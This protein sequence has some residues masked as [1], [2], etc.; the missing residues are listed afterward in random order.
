MSLSR[1]GKYD[2]AAPC[3]PCQRAHAFEV[4]TR[5][6]TAPTEPPCAYDHPDLVDGPKAR[7]AHLENELVELRELLAAAN[8]KLA[9]CTCGAAAGVSTNVL[10]PDGLS[11]S[12][13]NSQHASAAT[14]PRLA[15]EQIPATTG[16]MSE[17]VPE[18]PF[19]NPAFSS[20]SFGAFLLSNTL[21]NPGTLPIPMIS[22]FGSSSFSTGGTGSATSDV[23]PSAWPPGL[24]PPAVL[25]HLVETF[26]A[27][28]PLASRLIHKPTFMVAL[29]QL[30][31]SLDF[32]H[33]ALLH[34]IC[35]LA[36]LYSPIIAD[37][38]LAAARANA[39]A[40]LF[41][42]SISGPLDPTNGEQDTRRFP[43][44]LYDLRNIWDEGFGVS[45]I[46]LAS[47][48]L[49][50]S[51]REGDRLL[52]ML[53][54][55]IICTWYMY[56]MG[57]TI[58]VYVWVSN[59]T[60]LAGPLG[61]YASEGF[62]P[63]SRLPSN[64]LFLF[65]KPKTPSE[66]ETI[67]NIFWISYVMER[68]YNAG[69]AW[70]LTI[71]DEDISQM[72]PCRFSDFITGEHVPT[73]NRQR[74][75]TE[76]MLFTHPTLTTDSWTL[77][78]KASILISRVRS[79]NSRYRISAVSKSTG[80][81]ME[82][83]GSPTESEEFRHLDQTIA[84]FTRNIPRAFRDPVGTT[85]DPLLYTAHLLPHMA[86]IQLHDPHAKPDSPNDHSAMQMLAATRAILDLIYKL[87]GTTYDLLHLD[88]SC[89]FAWFLAGVAI[90][91]FLKAK[92]D[93]KNED[94]ILG[95]EQE[96]GVVK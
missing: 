71:N 11:L 48:S 77:Y 9:G 89:S 3:G 34:A 12:T 86:M 56:S 16:L 76:N 6:S 25:Y 66:A 72:L 44:S 13:G 55:A 54:A 63:L 57:F 17:I 18:A 31:T 37:P 60:K 23:L 53:Q 65:G 39:A 28:V 7:I 58:G 87:S 22:T 14:A 26:F 68:V 95:L 4:R 38:T 35:G 94:E 5:P 74:I 10:E 85:V 24:P 42:P 81:S 82:C 52:Q 1:N 69:T 78:I 92:I 84:S 67:R 8:A 61:I 51:V 62:E 90:I 21:G 75:F 70:P 15:L 93:A 47:M 36:S 27:S 32:P 59:V 29:R 20:P 49:R 19:P 79:F 2:G 50:L 91:R 73:H 33:I 43:K 46:R 45:H 80:V 40:G 41:S 88:H 64:M 96:L 83:H 30:P